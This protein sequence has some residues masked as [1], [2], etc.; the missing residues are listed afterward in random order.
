MTLTGQRPNWQWLVIAADVWQ[1][2]PFMFLIL[3]A[4][5]RRFPRN[6]KQL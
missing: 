2:T 6:L 1:W 3:L 5:C 4:A